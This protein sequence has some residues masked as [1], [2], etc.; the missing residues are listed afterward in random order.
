MLDVGVVNLTPFSVKRLMSA[1]DS[2]TGPVVVKSVPSVKVPV[3][4]PFV[5]LYSDDFTWS[6]LSRSTKSP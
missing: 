1:S 2:C 5:L 6:S 3:I 4:W